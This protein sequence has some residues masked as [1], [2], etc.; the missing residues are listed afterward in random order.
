MK[1]NL[2][3][4][5][6]AVL[7]GML[8]AVTFFAFSQKT[9]NDGY[10][11]YILIP[12]GEFLMGDNFAEGDA[13]EVP[14]HKISLDAYY[15]GKYKITNRE[16][17]AFLADKGYEYA[18]Y[19]QAGGFAEYGKEPR[20]WRDARYYGGGLTGNENFPVVG[21]S[22]FEAQAFCKWLSLKTGQVY[23]LPYEAEWER[24]ARGLTQ[25][26][27][28]WGDDLDG[29][30]ANFENSGD[31]FEPGLT[32]IDYYPENVTS[33]GVYGM[34]GNVWEWCQDWYGGSAYY[35]ASEQSN[36]SGPAN[37][38]S[39]ILRA[40]GWVDSAYYQRAANRNSSFPENRNP[41]QGFRCVRE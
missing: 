6:T 11:D 5:R 18:K 27:Y 34:I 41:I 20:F 2:R 40:G 3:V 36:P 26:R 30:L 21:V 7:L 23:R 28:A 37:G 31:S 39:R 13:D 15:I 14:V 25:K 33:E 17:Q 10:G 1:V 9:V 29:S 16:Y 24:A 12:A 19:W 38:T 4:L 35:A 8:P 22:W 32:P